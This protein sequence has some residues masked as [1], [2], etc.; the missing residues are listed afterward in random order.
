MKKVVT[1]AES[2]FSKIGNGLKN[3]KCL[4]IKL[5]FNGRSTHICALRG[6]VE[7]AKVY[8]FVH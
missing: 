5:T 3:T 4:G 8:I 1:S 2:E 7:V 6:K